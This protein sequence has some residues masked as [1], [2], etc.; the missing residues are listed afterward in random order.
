MIPI[1]KE[2]QQCDVLIVGGG[3]AGLMAAISAAKQGVKV[4]VTEKANT[5]RSG[6]GATGCDHFFCYIPEIHGDFNIALKELTD[7]Q[8]GQ[9]GWSDESIQKIFLQRSYETVQDWMSWGINM[10][11]HGEWEFNG[12]TLPGHTC[13][14][15]KYDGRNQKA[16]LTQ[17]ALK[18]GVI[19]E[20]RTAVTEFLTDN[21]KRIIGAVAIDVSAE[22]PVIKLYQAKSIIATTGIAMR[23]YP[24][25][26][27]ACMF[28]V[29]NCPAGTAS[30]RAA[31]YRADATLVN[32]DIL[33]VHSGPRYFERVGKSTWIGVMKDSYKKQISPYVKV[34]TKDEAD[35]TGDV[36]SSVFTEK[37]KDGTGPVFMDCT[38][39]SQED[40]AYMQWG[41]DCEGGS[42]VLDAIQQ[43]N[44]DLNK[45]MV[46]FGKYKPIMQGNGIQINE[47]CATNVDGLFCAGDEA[48][49]FNCGIAGA[50]V[51]GR[52]AGENAAVYVQ[53]FKTSAEIEYH[54]LIAQCQQFYS[55][56]M[57]REKGAHWKELNTALQQIMDDYASIIFKRSSTT[58][59]AGYH[60]LSDLE[61]NAKASLCCK[62]S[63]ELMR[64]LEAFDLLLMGKLVFLTANERKE[65]RGVHQRSDY[66]YTNPLLH[67]QFITIS[68]TQGKPLIN[69]RKRC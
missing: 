45:H 50:A 12:H 8:G 35:I 21:A 25:T 14:W 4:I 31:A 6:S 5:R 40:K 32:L 13:H 29:C 11:P 64:A 69:W 19:I 57:A 58:L 66:T 61:K 27:P 37:M 33:W 59:D 22:Q 49:N 26:T 53:N 10:K 67:G 3:I 52:I 7:S 15:L 68:Q 42:S 18:C 41:I 23:L 48:G 16:I 54:P 63:H 34:A 24:S 51:T 36:W 28:N 38:E 65:S 2:I 62:N 20:N 1:K 9:L 43:Q 56:L 47:Q 44:I 55:S 60:Y 46:E 39:T 30:G 17:Q